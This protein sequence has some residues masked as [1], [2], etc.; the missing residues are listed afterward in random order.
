M[1]F[2]VW[3]LTF[4]LISMSTAPQPLQRICEGRPAMNA[5]SRSL[6][7]LTFTLIFSSMK[8]SAGTLTRLAPAIVAPRMGFIPLRFP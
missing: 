7:K 3:R 1:K 2:T 4:F 6:V 5:S 8:P